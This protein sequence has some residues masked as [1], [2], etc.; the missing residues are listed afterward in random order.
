[1]ANLTKKDL[2]K[3]QVGGLYVDVELGEP[4]SFHTDVEKKK[5]E[6]QGYTLT[7]DDR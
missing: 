2:K 5:A 4:E 1:M 3:L 7:D 6:D